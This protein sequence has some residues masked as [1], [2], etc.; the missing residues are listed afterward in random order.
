MEM[1]PALFLVVPDTPYHENVPILIGAYIIHCCLYSADT[2]PE[3]S[4]ESCQQPGELLNDALRLGI[5]SSKGVC[6]VKSESMST[7]A[8]QSNQ[9]VTIRGIIIILSLFAHFTR[10][11]W[12]LHTYKKK[13]VHCGK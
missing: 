9:T 5:N 10:I 11:K 6:M 13:I 3:S 4:E 7:I 1:I 12:Q 2:D 8:V